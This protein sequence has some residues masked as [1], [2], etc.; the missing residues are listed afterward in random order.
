MLK[1]KH[2]RT[3]GFTL[4]ELLVV[5]SIIALLIGI[6]LPALGAARKSAQAIVCGGN[7]RSVGQA[8]TTY[9]TDGKD[10]YPPSYVYPMDDKGNWRWADQF[11]G[12]TGTSVRY[13]HWSY[14]VSGKQASGDAAF[15]CPTLDNGGLPRTVPGDDREDWQTP[16]FFP[17]DLQA[18]R[19][20][21][22]GNAALIPRNKFVKS[23]KIRQNKMVNTAEVTNASNT[24]LAA[25]F[26]ENAYLVRNSSESKSHRPIQVLE[27]IGNGMDILG[28]G[29]LGTKRYRYSETGL[30]KDYNKL[31]AS[32]SFG[33]TRISDNGGPDLNAI[34]RHHSGGGA[35]SG[36]AGSEGSSNFVF[37]DGHVERTTPLETIE[38]RRWGDHMYSVTGNGTSIR[39]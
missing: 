10:L 4:I 14:M 3:K 2:S 15:T 34:G 21:Y 24:I 32:T 18:P 5:I 35:G 13:L 25:E 33:E 31:L 39:D 7:Q 8:M 37:A 6:L 26:S 1:Q 36:G 30:F 27:G 28:E 11:P 23:F 22:S 9:T 12:N 38:E 16:P 20:A 19:M 29:V 17:E